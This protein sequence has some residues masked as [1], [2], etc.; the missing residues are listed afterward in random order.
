MIMKMLILDKIRKIRKERLCKWLQLILTITI[1]EK[2]LKLIMNLMKIYLT[3][4]IVLSLTSGRKRR[5]AATIFL[6]KIRVKIRVMIHLKLE[7]GKQRVT[8]SMPH[9]SLQSSIR[10]TDTGK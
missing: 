3:H 1:M 10:I 7:K 9:S 8:K 4:L 5:A 2:I 6:I